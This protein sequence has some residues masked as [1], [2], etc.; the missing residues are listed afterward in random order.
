MLDQK[1]FNE[2]INDLVEEAEEKPVRRVKKEKPNLKESIY[3][4]QPHQ[5]EDW[6]K[7]NGEKPFR[8]A[9]IFDWLYNKRVKTFEEMSNL[10][11]GLRDKL[12]ANFALS[13]LSTIIKQE[14]K[15]GT[16]KFLFQLQDGYSIETVLM[17]HE[18]GNSVCVTTQVGCRIGCTF[19]ASTLGGLKRHLLAGEIVE[20]VVKVQQTLD[21]VS[22]RVSH[23]VIMGIGE[24]FD[25][26]DAMMN[27]LKVINHE[28]GLNIGARHITVS[29]SGIVPKI[30]QF[31]DEQLQINFA[32]SLHA[33]N[34]EARQ[35]LMPIA[36]AYKLEELMEAV[37]YYTKKTGR[38]VSFE[39]GLM[40]GE[41]DS[42]EIAEELSAL[43]KGIKC[44]VNLIP[45][46]Y[47]PERDY[48]RTSRSQIF[49]F[50]KTLKKNGINVTIRREQGSDI[51]AACGQLRAQE[52]SEETR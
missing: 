5:L 44:H 11:K 40:S 12:A 28:K 45:V 43:I 23:I 3:S 26:Y 35:K 33:P 18:Y 17:R 31:A 2:R 47:V 42:V 50:E 38:R 9:Q 10:S 25:N 24:P 52:R 13:T 41:N 15:D 21:E 14:S 4:F 49:A 29:T 30:Y 48:V 20:Q 37:R 6:L 34:Q 16:I 46:N 36:R 39:Y 7:E 8:A 22:E 32:V 27:F 1:E 19:C 51:A